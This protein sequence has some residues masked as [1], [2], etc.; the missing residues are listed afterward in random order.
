MRL[1]IGHLI[2]GETPLIAAALTDR[3]VQELDAA[4]AAPA[5]II[6]LRVDM[7]DR[8]APEYLADI[9]SRCREKFGKPLI[10]TVRDVREGGKKEFAERKGLYRLLVPLSDAADVEIN[11]GDVMAGV[12]ALCS[13]HGKVL[14][15]S[16]HHFEA[17]PDDAVLEQTARQG[18]RQ[19]ADIVKIA[20][21]A[22]TRED[23]L[24][25]LFFTFRHRD[26]GMITM[27]MGA[28]GLP[29]RVFGFL[30]GSL[31]TYGYVTNPS[32]P[33]QLSVAELADILS[34]LGL[35]P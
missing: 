19:G 25:L 9:F 22:S 10:V 35:R 18:R 12:R 1:S 17:T 32:A 34:R 2:L 24:R 27:S 28:A 13:S 20:A 26:E 21:T 29:S 4:A 3:D 31:I 16:S 5:D 15:G 8:T 30:F 7:F 6:E 11:A 33:G 23:M 14:I